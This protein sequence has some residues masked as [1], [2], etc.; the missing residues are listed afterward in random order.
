[1]GAS[2]GA[3]GVR[4]ASHKG[5]LRAN[6]KAVNDFSER[7]ILLYWM[8][9]CQLEIGRFDTGLWREEEILKEAK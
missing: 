9:F 3:C 2:G 1:M 7:V 6:R 8:V 4:G 5:A